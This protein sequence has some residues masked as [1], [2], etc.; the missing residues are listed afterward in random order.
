MVASHWVFSPNGSEEKMKGSSTS[1]SWSAE[2]HDGHTPALKANGEARHLKKTAS[3]PTKVKGANAM[4]MIFQATA[5][6]C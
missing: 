3:L 1:S 4:E 2:S 6:L 5:D